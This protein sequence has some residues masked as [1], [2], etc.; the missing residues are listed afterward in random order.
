M[1]TTVTAAR[2]DDTCMS[3][4]VERVSFGQIFGISRSFRRGGFF[5]IR[6]KGW[7]VRFAF[8]GRM[9][10]E[11]MHCT[12]YYSRSDVLLPMFCVASR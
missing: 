2:I 10:D 6:V 9:T 8:R 3:Y 4:L 12:F 11:F 1:V 7:S 5:T